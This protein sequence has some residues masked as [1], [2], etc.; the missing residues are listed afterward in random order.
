MRKYDRIPRLTAVEVVDHY[1]LRV[2][3]DD[4]LVRDV[5]LSDDLWGPIFEP[6]KDADYF[7]KAFI[8]G[9]SVAWPN[10]ADLDPLVLHGDAELARPP[11]RT[12]Q[13]P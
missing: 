4:G 6:L 3:F 13:R 7:A 10:G 12:E 8:D 5:D 1:V 11:H 9:N 2:S